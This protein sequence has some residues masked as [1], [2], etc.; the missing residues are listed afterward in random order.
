M[1]VKVREDS[2][3]RYNMV[4][5]VWLE[6]VHVSETCSIGVT[7]IERHPGVAV[8]NGIAVLSLHELEQVVLYNG[9]LPHSGSLS[10][11]GLSRDAVTE[12]KNVLV[13]IVL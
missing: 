8:V 7:E 4:E 9:C 5:C 12:G 6:V 1:E 13:R 11:G 2:I 10:A 3:V